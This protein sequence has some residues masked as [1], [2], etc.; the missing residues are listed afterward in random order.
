[1]FGK[2]SQGKIVSCD[3]PLWRRQ[4]LDW[5]YQ[6]FIGPIG[7][8]W[9]RLVTL[10]MTKNS[11]MNN[12]RWS[13]NNKMITVGEDYIVWELDE[14]QKTAAHN[15]PSHLKSHCLLSWGVSGHQQHRMHGQHNCKMQ[16]LP[17]I[18]RYILQMNQSTQFC[19]LYNFN[20]GAGRRGYRERVHNPQEGKLHWEL[21]FAKNANYCVCKGLKF[22]C[23]NSIVTAR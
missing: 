13:D 17:T 10:V 3:R 18:S 4:R 16:Q 5:G 21:F 6:Q 2:F 12:F 1:M 19:C 20:K 9:A 15:N 11:E 7:H 22:I 23:I 14:R 8:L